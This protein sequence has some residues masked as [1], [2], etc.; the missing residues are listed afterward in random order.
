ME[1]QISKIN[2]SEMNKKSKLSIKSHFSAELS[3]RNSSKVQS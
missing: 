2:R 3:P 1:I